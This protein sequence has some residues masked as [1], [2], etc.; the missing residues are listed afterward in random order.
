MKKLPALVLAA[1]LLASP[2]AMAQSIR[3]TGSTTI[4][5]VVLTPEIRADIKAKLG[6]DV[7]AVGSSSG[8]GFKDLVEGKAPCSMS[9]AE[10]DV[11]TK[12]ANIT[13]TA[14][15]KLWPLGADEVVSI[16]HRNNAVKAKALTKEQWGAIFSGK[17]KNWSEVGGPDLPIVVVISADEGSA[18]RQEVQ[19]DVMGGTA[20]PA[21]ARKATTTKDEV[22]AVGAT[23]GAVGAVGKGLAVGNP[24]VA[25]M[26]EPLLK[27]NM[28][29]ITKEPPAGFDKLVGYLTSPEIKAKV[30][31]E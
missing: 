14:A 1:A 28:I 21:D 3:C 11:L 17:V 23:L 6:I 25:I 29:L 18:T 7:E 10:F 5:N 13:D 19:K 26:K 22:L 9:T 20:Y 30:G 2:A 4:T 24:A 12:R 27:R 8:A 15:F 31:I 16:V